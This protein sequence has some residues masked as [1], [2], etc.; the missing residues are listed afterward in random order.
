MYVS[1]MQNRA[2]CDAWV[3]RGQA[4]GFALGAVTHGLW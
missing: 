1:A 2:R 4:A 3:Q